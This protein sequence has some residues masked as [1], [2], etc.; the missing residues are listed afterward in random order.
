MATA[1]DSSVRAMFDKKMEVK[2]FKAATT[3][4]KM[5]LVNLYS[6]A[7]SAVRA[8]A[9]IARR[10]A[11]NWIVFCK[12]SR[13]STGVQE[14][15]ISSCYNCYLCTTEAECESEH[16]TSGSIACPGWN[17]MWGSCGTY[18]RPEACSKTGAL[19]QEDLIPR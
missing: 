13:P 17:A 10:P 18:I 2:R 6:S 16:V 3:A 5:V 12:Y 15:P 9:A 19:N 1:G 8:V 4:V 11:M 14:D 7:S